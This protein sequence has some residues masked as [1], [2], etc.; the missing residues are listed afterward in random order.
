MP[1]RSPVIEQNRSIIAGFLNRPG[2]R[3]P[4]TLDYKEVRL[5]ASELIKSDPAFKFCER[6]VVIKQL[7]KPRLAYGKLPASFELLFAIGHS[8]HDH[9][10]NRWIDEHPEGWRAL[11]RWHCPCKRTVHH[12][13]L[14]PVSGPPMCDTCQRPVNI[15]DEW[16]IYSE[17][18]HIVWHPDLVLVQGDDIKDDYVFNKERD[19][20]HVF[21]IKGIDRKSVNFSTLDA[22]LGE[23]M[24]QGSF[25]WWAFYVH[26]YKMHPT[27][28]YIYADRR[29]E[30]LFTENPYKEF[31][32]IPSPFR[33]I[34]KYFDKAMLI[35]D[36]IAKRS[37]PKRTVCSDAGCQRALSCHVPVHCYGLPADASR[38]KT[39]SAKKRGIV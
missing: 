14:S 23:H 19:P 20:V 8:L 13:I 35:L 15:Y 12:G 25:Y 36:S 5:H 4:R 31:Q 11:G 9:V 29:L 33:R 38:L 34:E 26:D 1:M 39:K 3:I 16:E 30:K 37:I 2:I 32:R 7:L 22:P 17:D 27:V 10:R 18:F 28:G 6:E 24:L 21:E